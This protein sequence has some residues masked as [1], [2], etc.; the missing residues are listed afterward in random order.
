MYFILFPQVPPSC[1]R[2]FAKAKLIRCIIQPQITPGI[3]AFLILL[4]ILVLYNWGCLQICSLLR[5]DNRTCWEGRAFC[6]VWAASAGAWS[7]S[8]QLTSIHPLEQSAVLGD[9]EGRL[10]SSNALRPA[11]HHQSFRDGRTN[12]K[13]S[14]PVESE[15]RCPVGL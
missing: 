3:R 12:L 1:S 6:Q 13:H 15:A 7:W 11:E 10:G 14:A 8:L 2:A 5:A 4:L 9:K